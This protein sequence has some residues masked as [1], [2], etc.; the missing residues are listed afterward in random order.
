MS[1]TKCKKQDK[2]I[3][4]LLD[5]IEW[6]RTDTTLNVKTKAILPADHPARIQQ[7][8]GHSEP[9]VTFSIITKK[10]SRFK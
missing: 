4:E 7:T 9:P 3:L 2:Y 1:P 10:Q 6:E 5:L 8:I